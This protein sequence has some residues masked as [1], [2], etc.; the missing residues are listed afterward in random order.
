MSVNRWGATVDM[1]LSR[2]RL[3]G[4]EPTADEFGGED[5]VGSALD[6]AADTIAQA[7]PAPVR[8]LLVRPDL[9]IVEAR[10]AAGQTIVAL[11]IGPAVAGKV[12][13][14]R[15]VPSQ[16][17]S[18]PQLSTSPWQGACQTHAQPTPPGPAPE[19]AEDQ[20]SLVLPATVA[21]AQPLDRNSMVLASWDVDT[22]SPDYII[23]SMANVVAIGAAAMLGVKVYPQATSQW[24]FVGRL[25]ETFADYVERLGSGAWVPAEVRLLRTWAPVEPSGEAGQV[26]GVAKWRG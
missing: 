9:V 6:M 16:F 5:E 14:W 8:D 23:P 15:G 10:A 3:E 11:P 19:L 17:I 13:I 24:E 21:L 7:A 4:Y 2:F 26:V 18:K 12:H 1:V 25:S 20:F 22:A